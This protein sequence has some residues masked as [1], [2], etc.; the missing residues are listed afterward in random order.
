MPIRYLPFR[1][2]RETSLREFQQRMTEVGR[3]R[4]GRYN[5][6]YP[7]KL[8]TFRFTSVDESL[9]RAVAAEYGG[10]ARPYTPQRS[11]RSEWEVISERDAVLVY[12]PQQ[13]IDP[14]LE[15]WRPGTCIRRCD[16]VTE[17]I[18]DEA[19]LCAAGRVS[20]DD[21][22]KPTIRVQLMLAEVPGLGTWRLESHGEYATAELSTLAPLIAQVPMPIPAQLRLRQETRRPWVAEKNKFETTT[23]YV[24]YLSIS[25]ATPEQVVIGGDALTRALQAAGAP[26]LE[27]SEPQRAIASD[28]AMRLVDP[29]DPEDRVQAAPAPA[30]V[31][32]TLSDDARM[33]ILAKIEE[34]TTVERLTA[35]ANTLRARGVKDSRVKG[36]LQ[37]KAAGIKAQAALDHQKSLRAAQQRAADGVREIYDGLPDEPTAH[38]MAGGADE[39]PQ[40][41]VGDTAE[42]AGVTFVKVSDDPFPPEPDLDSAMDTDSELAAFYT[43]AN[44]REWTTAQ[45]NDALKEFAGVTSMSKVDASTIHRMR[46]AMKAGQV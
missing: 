12:V 32:K 29:E 16:G 27:A 22:C 7:E 33:T 8:A 5:G 31:P 44:A 36:A 9:I 20:K 42:A 24:P 11:S 25:I 43:M 45:A 30:S 34:A 23:F 15:A 19:C 37:S 46:K 17:T 10:E 18:K 21:F 2:G 35:I 38:D 40:Y 14:W 13:R 4:T 39:E 1:E 26:A 6:K 3:I 41:A 28:A